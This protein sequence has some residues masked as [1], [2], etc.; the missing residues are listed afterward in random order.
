MRASFL[1]CTYSTK[2]NKTN[3][4]KK[5]LFCFLMMPVCLCAQQKN[6]DTLRSKALM[7]KRFM[8]INHYRPLQWNDSTSPLLYNKWLETIDEEKLFLTQKDIV[9]LSGYKTKLDDEMNGNGWAFF[10]SS[11]NLLAAGIKK[12]DS[13]LN[14]FL[15]QPVDFSKPDVE[16][17]P[18]KNYALNEQDFA[19]RWQRYLK[20]ELLSKISNRYLSKKVVLTATPPADFSKIEIEERVKLRRRENI[21]LKSLQQTPRLFLLEKQDEYLNAIAWCYDPHS[22]YFNEKEKEEFNADVS[23]KEFSAGLSFAENEKG[24]KEINFLE[25]GGSA[26]KSGQLHK[27]DVLLN[28]KVNGKENDIEEITGKE[29][30]ELLQSGGSGE[31]EVTVRTSADEIKT[32]SLPQEKINSNE[33]IVKSYLIKG[34]NNIGY[35]NLPGF[36]SREEEGQEEIKYDGCANDMSKEI[37]K[38]KKDNIEGLI[39]DLRNNGGGSMWEAMQ[40]AGIFIDAGPVASI[41]DKAGKVQF[42]K[43]P[44]RGTIYDGPL[45]VLINGASASASEFFSA[46]LQDYNRALIVGGTTYGKGTAQDVLPLDTNK[47][48]ANKKYDDFIKVTENKFYRINGK[49]VQWSG[50]KPDIDLPDVYADVQ[51]KERANESALIPDESKKGTYTAMAQ[52]PVNNLKTKSQARVGSDPYFKSMSEFSLW[53]SKYKLGTSIPLQ[54]S[55]FIQYQQKIKEAFALLKKDKDNAVKLLTVFNNNFD[56]QRI[57]ISNSSEK[58]VNETYLKNIATDNEITEAVKIFEDWIVK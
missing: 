17:W 10:N 1:T 39:I 20:W 26:W 15:A 45:I 7:V 46:T 4:H 51:F 44:N 5:I 3:L 57:D 19:K 53:I 27:G 8:E 25:P 18:N 34:K 30:A 28:I 49:T 48:A 32:V 2:M 47:I 23:A 21:Y 33:G 43:D 9:V 24:D 40:L 14:A 13:V 16:E 6:T 35:I 55:T 22:N 58:Q 37:I 12:A 11:T 31:V 52:L 56:K 36:Y 50:V 54:W 42:L 41:K 29:V 38:L